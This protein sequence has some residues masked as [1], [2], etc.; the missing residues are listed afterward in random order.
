MG[1]VLEIRDHYREE[2][3]YTEVHRVNDS[4]R[5]GRALAGGERGPEIRRMGGK[6]RSYGH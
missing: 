2:N 1:T 6:S 3:K 4:V 5:K